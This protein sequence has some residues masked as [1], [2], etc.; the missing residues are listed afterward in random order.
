MTLAERVRALPR[1]WPGFESIRGIPILL[2]LLPSVSR[3][4]SVLLGVGVLLAAALPVAAIALTGLLVGSIPAAVR[5]GLD[6]AAGHRTLDLLVAVGVLIVVQRF[7]APLLRAVSMTLGRETDRY[8]QDR[9]LAAVGRPGGI[10]HLEDPDVLAHVRLVKGLGADAQRPGLAV[11]GLGYVLPSWLQ[12]LGSAVVLLFFSWWIGLL[13]LVVWPIVVFAMQ[14]EYLRVGEVGYGRSD[15]LRRAEYLRDVAL[16]P[17]AGKEVR[18]WGM[19]GWLVAAFERAW[20]TAMAPVWK[21]RSPRGSVLFGAS[22]AVLAVNAVSYGLLAWAATRGDL[23]VAAVAIYT[24]ALAG[25]NSYTAFDDRN[26]YL[27]YAAVTVPKVLALDARLGGPGGYSDASGGSSRAPVTVVEPTA[28]ATGRDRPRTDVRFD[29]VTFRYPR[30][31]RTALHGLDLT[32][33]A[34]RSLAIVGENG[35]GKTSLVKLLCGLYAPTEGRL[36]VD[37][38]DLAGLDPAAW[39][40]Q[41]AVLF[42]DFARYHLPVR[43]N[44]GLGAPAYAHD[45]DRLRSAAHK[46]GV[47]DLVES[48]PH[49]FDTVLSREYTG[50]VDLS[51]GQWQR[52]A[53]AR[54][55]FAV[56]AGARLLILDEPTAA[57]DVRAEAELYERFLELTEGLTTCLISHRFSTVRRADRIVVLADGGVVE[58][59][60]HEELMDLDGRYAE[61]FTLQASRF[62]DEQTAHSADGQGL[63]ATGEGTQTHA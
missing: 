53:L 49:G 19:L 35:A 5:G 46:A 61:M 62:L 60:S 36:L 25:V 28:S 9:V 13:W 30:G 6:S 38:H 51:G 34:G 11:E 23:S 32:I 56:Q 16:G 21:V 22:G 4:L 45:E 18:V 59:G 48:L 58:D 29:D 10:A 2:R 40:D 42:Q 12:A 20:Y 55:M 24:Q 26:V 3:R 31:E 52:I 1:R 14:Q 37:G 44:I 47:L 54:A 17:A 57:L 50:G 27:S 39:R 33:A 8:L 7:V 43:D 63:A 15:A 41:V